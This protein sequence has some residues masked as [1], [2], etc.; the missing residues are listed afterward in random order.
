MG[1]AFAMFLSLRNEYRDGFYQIILVGVFFVLSGIKDNF[2][3][4]KE[5]VC[6]YPILPGAVV[7]W[8]AY[9]TINRPALVSN[10][11]AFTAFIVIFAGY[12]ISQKHEES[13]KKAMEWMWLV[14]FAA[15]AIGVA[16]YLIIHDFNTRMYFLFTNPI[17]EGDAAIVFTMISLFYID[18]TWQKVAGILLSIAV[19]VTGSLR[20]ASAVLVLLV[21]SYVVWN[22]KGIAEKI[23]VNFAGF[24]KR[25]TL[26]LVGGGI[27]VIVLGGAFFLS[28]NLDGGSF[29]KLFERYMSVFSSVT[30]DVYLN[31]YGDLSLKIRIMAIDQALNAYREGSIF[32]HLFGHGLLSGYYAIKP[33]MTMLTM[34]EAEAAGPIEN[35]FIALFSDY[36]ALALVLY[37]GVYVSALCSIVKSKLET[38]R[39]SAMFV[40]VIM[41]LSTFI[42]MEYWINLIFFVWVF[43]G[44]YLGYLIKAEEKH[45]LLPS[46]LFGAVVSLNLFFLPVGYSLIR[47]LMN[48][49]VVMIGKS[50]AVAFMV[51]CVGIYII[52]LWYLCQLIS[53]GIL[54][55][56]RDVAVKPVVIRTVIAG[57]LMALL[58]IIGDVSIKRVAL[59]LDECLNGEKEIVAVIK[60]NADG[61]IYNDTYPLIY[62]EYFGNIKGTLFSGASLAPKKDT[63]VIVSRD[64]EQYLLSKAGF[65]YLPISSQDAIYTNDDGVIKALNDKGYNLT[66]YNTE[67]WKVKDDNGKNADLYPGEYTADFSLKF[68]T[69]YDTTDENGA[70]NNAADRIDSDYQVCRL[71]ICADNV[72]TP[73]ADVPIMRS[74]FDDNGELEYSVPFSCYAKD[75]S[76]NV[77]AADDKVASAL[78]VESISYQRTPSIDMRVK[79][80]EEGRV[81][82][83][84]FFDLDGNP[85]PGGEGSHAREYEYGNTPNWSVKRYLGMDLKPYVLDDTYAELRREF[86]DKLLVTREAYYDE[87]GNLR[88]QSGGFAIAEYEYDDLGNKTDFRYYDAT[89]EPVL[90]SEAYWHLKVSYND[91]K[92]NI[93]EMYYGLDDQPLM[94]ADGSYGHAREYD[95]NGNVSYCT[96]LDENGKPTTN[97]WG[98]T[99]W[100]RAYN[101]KKQNIHEEYYDTDGNLTEVD[102]GYSSV[103]YE[104]DDNGVVSKKIFRNLEGKIVGQE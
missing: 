43:I 4:L 84:E 55:Y 62:D 40:V 24:G 15:E 31:F 38:V 93:L 20:M 39:I 72:G 1:L 26:Y 87:K 46:L 13:V 6:N 88:A 47:T 66:G 77:S 42:D 83:E 90:V 8:T 68:D 11:Y 70:E 49:L 5:Y 51:V 9:F 57:L 37:L 85:V 97:A 67:V 34:S 28:K 18:K 63:T 25:R 59:M 27:L 16:N 95:D 80:N 92:Q 56:Q 7:L 94:Q 54:R 103:D 33:T 64:E 41:T 104:Y 89:E 19:V 102:G 74:Q 22:R 48:S 36:G 45:F 14:L 52:L 21:I 78:S 2:S 17:A 75:C 35:A 71:T 86:N 23:G 69:S 61:I 65:L 60:K 82:L 101:D 53:M 50:G 79:V 81:I 76:F 32:N 96:Y 3:K 91:K 10:R 12:C 100:K 98:Y 44:L 30:R 99:S 58:L 29:N 73:Y